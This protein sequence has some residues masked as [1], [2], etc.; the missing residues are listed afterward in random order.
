VTS[1]SSAWQAYHP[2]AKRLFAMYEARYIQSAIWRVA[3]V[4][5]WMI[6]VACAVRALS[7]NTAGLLPSAIGWL[8]WVTALAALTPFRLV[9]EE[10]LATLECARLRGISTA[11]VRISAWG[12]LAFVLLRLFLTRGLLVSLLASFRSADTWF[13][14]LPLS[15]ALSTGIGAFLCLALVALRA[16]SHAVSR[17]HPRRLFL[18]ALLLPPLMGEFV[19]DVP[20]VTGLSAHWAAKC[21]RLLDV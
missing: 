20:S 7:D 9:G 14:S 18:L 11:S 1:P 12:A 8:A 3:S 6:V 5:S 21:A 19:G 4:A 10:H 17:A 16:L 2:A 13:V 15:M